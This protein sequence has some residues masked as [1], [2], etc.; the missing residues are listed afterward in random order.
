MV[1]TFLLKVC[2][3]SLP[4]CEN[5]HER[6]IILDTLCPVCGLFSETIGHV[7]WS[8]SA[9]TAVWM[10]CTR[11]IQK[12]SIV[13]SDSLLFIEA[14]FSLLE[15]E[16]LELV[17]FLSRRLWLRRNIVV[18]GGNLTPPFQVFRQGVEALEDYRL[19]FLDTG[20]LK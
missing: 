8:C 5:L 12:L 3:N 19:S 7:L 9:A 1:Q 15:D 16:D 2:N 11:R 14:L 13:E 17:F 4:T 20:L 10:E 18:F 6:K